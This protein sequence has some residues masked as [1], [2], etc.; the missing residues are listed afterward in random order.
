LAGFAVFLALYG[1]TA[2]SQYSWHLQLITR[3]GGN[4]EHR[5]GDESTEW[6]SIARRARTQFVTV[7]LPCSSAGR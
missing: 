6:S 2:E 7:T 5:N 1:L 3:Q 4:F